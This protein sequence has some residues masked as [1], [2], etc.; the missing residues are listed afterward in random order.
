MKGQQEQGR[1]AQTMLPGFRHPRPKR[2]LPPPPLC[3][4][5]QPR[6]QQWRPRRNKLTSPTLCRSA[7]C[8]FEGQGLGWDQVVSSSIAVACACCRR[9][10]RPGR[11]SWQG[12]CCC[13]L[14]QGGQRRGET[15]VHV[16]DVDDGVPVHDIANREQ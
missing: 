7:G 3:L 12:C 6:R 11:Y 10:R 13:V 8:V 9:Y 1:A 16:N 14:C 4:L 2:H 15:R 5:E